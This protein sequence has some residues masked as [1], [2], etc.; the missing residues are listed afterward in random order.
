VKIWPNSNLIKG[1]ER[2][3]KQKHRHTEGSMKH[4]MTN[5]QTDSLTI[6]ARENKR[7]Q[8]NKHRWTEDKKNG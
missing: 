6:V 7:K 3:Q 5:K 1:D 2:K 8:K 4:R